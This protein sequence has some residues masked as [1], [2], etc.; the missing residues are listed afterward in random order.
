PLGRRA[1]DAVGELLQL[2]GPVRQLVQGT[3]V[4]NPQPVLHQPHEFVAR[5]EHRVLLA[6]DQ[7]GVA[8]R[9][10][11]TPGVGVA[12]RAPVGPVLEAV[13]L[14]RDFDVGAP[15][16]PTLEAAFAAAPLDALA[17]RLDLVGQLGPPPDGVDVALDGAHALPAELLA[18]EDDAGAGQGLP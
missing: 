8:D 4:V 11:R 6:A 17:H 2:L 13:H 18:P 9:V 10:Q 1:A 3:V 14:H 5:A 12:H 15:A 7:A 16:E